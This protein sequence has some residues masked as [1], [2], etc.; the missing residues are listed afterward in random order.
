MAPDLY[1]GRSMAACYKAGM[2]ASDSSSRSG[3]LW[4]LPLLIIIGLSIGALQPWGVDELLAFG[5][6]LAGNPW[7]LVGVV[8]AMAVLFT[9]G[10]PGSLAF[11]LLAPF[12]T[13]VV[14]TF[15]L[16]LGSVAG[17]FGAYRF[18]ARLRGEWE[19]EGFSRRI[20]HLLSRQGGILTQMA[21]RTLPG[22]PH[23]VVNFAGGVL[24]LGLSGFL[25]AA[26]IGLTVKWGVY[27]S[28]VH[29][30]VEAV[31]AGDA[32]DLRTLL[33]LLV[34]SGLLLGGAVARRWVAGRIDY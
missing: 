8:L 26:I 13:P 21:L 30:L 18:S 16:V 1:T 19:P 28:A 5:R 11:W 20:V 12:Q 22:F 7:F 25:A 4:L 10:L 9:F 3:R 33:P 27:A 24:G 29:G 15:L 17:A 23:S 6:D 32:L 31:E 14:A 34:L 2:N